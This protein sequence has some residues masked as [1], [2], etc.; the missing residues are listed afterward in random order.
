MD[1]NGYTAERTISGA[2][3][4]GRYVV[5]E[6][7]GGDISIR[8]YLNA[9]S[10][11]NGNIGTAGGALVSYDWSIA[12]G[13]QNVS[14][15]NIYVGA[16]YQIPFTQYQEANFQSAIGNRGQFVFALGAEG[17]ITNS[18]V[19]YGQLTFPTTN[20]ANSYGATGGTYSPVFT[21]GLGFKF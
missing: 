7:F 14:K 13:F 1:G 15:A 3:L 18:L 2:T 5:T 20:A 21:T 12:K 16:G 17:R 11:P 6:K 8:P 19:G 10:G 4:Q 9:A